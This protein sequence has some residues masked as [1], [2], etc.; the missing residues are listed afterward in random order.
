[1][2]VKKNMKLT[3]KSVNEKQH[4]TLK[5]NE[6]SWSRWLTSSTLKNVWFGVFQA[7]IKAS[8]EREGV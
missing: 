1:M 3:V 4:I 7:F 8:K 5:I 2:Q 6:K